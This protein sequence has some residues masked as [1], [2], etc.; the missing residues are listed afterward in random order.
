M[1]RGEPAP[2]PGRRI[3]AQY[4][5]DSTAVQSNPHVDGEQPHT[6][7]IASDGSFASYIPAH[8]AISWAITDSNFV[9]IVRERYWVAGQPGEIRVCASCHGTNDESLHPLDPAPQNKPEALRLLLRDWKSS[10]AGVASKPKQTLP[11]LSNYPNPFG[12]QTEIN[13]SIPTSGVIKLK[14][15]NMLGEEVAE[16]ADRFFTE[17]EHR[18]YWNGSQL[19]IGTYFLRL[20]NGRDIIIRTLRIIR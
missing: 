9:P 14:V 13:F 7:R 1:T 8:R 11:T 19:P 17:G 18:V 15:M 6:V 3:L 2:I 10:H 12:S 20:Q 4:M 16:V 5:H